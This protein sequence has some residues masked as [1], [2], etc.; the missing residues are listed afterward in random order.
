MNQ[1][2]ASVFVGEPSDGRLRVEVKLEN[3]REFALIAAGADCAEGW[4]QATGFYAGVPPVYVRELSDDNVAGAV[5]AMANDLS[6]Y[7]LGYCARAARER[8]GEAVQPVKVPLVELA[9]KDRGTAVV[10]AT[11]GDGREFSILAATPE[12]FKGAFYGSNLAWYWGPSVLFLSKLDKALAKKAVDDMAKKGDRWLC[13]YDTP[14]TTLPKV[15][16]DFQAR[17][18]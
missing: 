9:G 5:S 2:L 6:G 15:L 11:L 16:E 10:Q 3:G 18:G 4:T 8:P 17:V 12:W 1:G 14:R 7:W 13:L